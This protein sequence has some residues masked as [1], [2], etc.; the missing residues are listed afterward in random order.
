MGYLHRL[1]C[2]EFAWYSQL[3]RLHASVSAG[4]GVQR[5]RGK[6]SKP[7]RP[8]TP[9]TAAGSI[10]RSCV[11]AP[12]PERLTEPRDGQPDTVVA[13]SS[14]CGSA[15]TRKAVMQMQSVLIVPAILLPSIYRMG[16]PFMHRVVLGSPWANEAGHVS[17]NAARHARLPMDDARARRP[18]RQVSAPSRGADAVCEMDR[19]DW[20]FDHP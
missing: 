18:L 10:R 7:M 14:A 3:R 20:D 2:H 9:G 12:A 17:R 16:A 13:T 11:H 6:T 5:G 15:T 8:S 4:S 1:I 19:V